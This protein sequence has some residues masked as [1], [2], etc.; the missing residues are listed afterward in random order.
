MRRAWRGAVHL[1]DVL[2]DMKTLKEWQKVLAGLLAMVAL[3]FLADRGIG[4]LFGQ[5]YAHSRYGN[6]HRQEY[7]LHDSKEKLLI[8][9]SSR[10][11]NHYVPQIFTDSIGMSC[12]NCG[13][14]GQSIYFHYGILSSYLERGDI[15][16]VVLWEVTNKD[17]VVTQGQASG[18]DA[19]VER[20][21]PNYGEYA[22]IDS[23]LLL[24]GWRER[25]LL[26]SR[27]Y[28]YNSKAVQLFKC[29]FLPTPEDHGYEALLGAMPP[30]RPFVVE[31]HES[32]DVLDEGKLLYVNKLIQ[33][34]RSNG[35]KLYFIESPRYYDAPFIGIDTLKALAAQN[36]IP[37]LDYRH[38]EDFMDPRFF[39]NKK[40]LN[41]FGAHCYSSVVAGELKRMITL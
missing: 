13:S 14:N 3:A 35:V 41:D 40:H 17:A 18:L 9:G 34:C 28:R 2:I 38:A 33:A 20:F 19:A 11:V 31:Q 8:L 6:Y 7:C 30:T 4:Y 32:A 10:A 15:P 22:S 37:F 29:L 5:A 23:V 16:K 36:D 12:Y 26:M 24:K 39:N 1:H 21:T 25:L 27:C